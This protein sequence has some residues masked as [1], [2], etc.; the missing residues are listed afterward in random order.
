MLLA[1]MCRF[2]ESENKGRWYRISRAIR[3]QEAIRGNRMK[4]EKLLK[5]S[6]DFFS[7]KLFTPIVNK[8]PVTR[9]TMRWLKKLSFVTKL[10]ETVGDCEAR[11]QSDKRA[12]ATRS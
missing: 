2:D 8:S 7:S 3:L 12:R 5:L 10:A 1:Q 4:R 11:R 6:F 9:V